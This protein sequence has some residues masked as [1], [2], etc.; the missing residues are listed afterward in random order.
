MNQQFIWDPPLPREWVPGHWKG[1][2]GTI[3]VPKVRVIR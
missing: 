1:P 2:E 3:A